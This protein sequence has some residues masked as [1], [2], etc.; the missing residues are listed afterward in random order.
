MYSPCI[1]QNLELIPKGDGRV[2]V[3]NKI[4]KK[5]Y[6]LGYNEYK[7]LSLLDGLKTIEEIQNQC[8]IYSISDIK[9]LINEFSKIGL[10]KVSE[11][12]QYNDNNI[13]TNQVENKKVL[14]YKVVSIMKKIIK[15]LT[16]KKGIIYPDKNLH[17]DKIIFRMFYFS[18]IYFSLPLFFIGLLISIATASI[19][20]SFTA[21]P[22]YLFIP[23]FLISISLHELSHVVVAKK[24]GANIAEVGLRLIIFIPCIYSSILG[25]SYIENK[26]KR[27]LIS[28]AGILLNL[29]IA[30]IGLIFTV[31]TNGATYNFFIWLTILNLMLVMLNLIFLLKFDG[32]YILSELLNEKRLHKNSLSYIMYIIKYKIFRKSLPTNI[33]VKLP[34]KKKTIYL[35]YGILNIA[36]ILFVVILAIINI[37]GLILSKV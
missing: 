21:P 35:V 27:I 7:V 13:N 25:I 16:F 11:T 18:I 9:N 5:T 15:I 6:S 29:Q 24:N 22:I 8:N 3:F 23:F 17:N 10:L 33:N 26:M 1:N 36:F 20:T 30:G 31:F 2:Y 19:N 32:Y 28:A 34:V 37:T 14:R 4:T 12:K